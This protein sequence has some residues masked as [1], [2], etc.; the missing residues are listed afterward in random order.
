MVI[1]TLTKLQH[2]SKANQ[3]AIWHRLRRLSRLC[4]LTSPCGVESKVYSLNVKNTTKNKF[5]DAYQRF[6]DADNI[7]YK[8]PKKLRVEPFVIHVP[9]EAR[10]NTIIACCGLLQ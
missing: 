3:K 7:E 9:T 8:K 10:I 5:F 1:K 2:L 4:I 6:C